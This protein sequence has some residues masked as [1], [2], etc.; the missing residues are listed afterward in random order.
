MKIKA[1]PRIKVKITTPK[2][3]RSENSSPRPPHVIINNCGFINE[4]ADRNVSK[5]ASGT[6]FLYKSITIGIVPYVHKGEI[7]PRKDA[8]TID[9]FGDLLT[10][11]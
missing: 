2:I 11:F 5:G 10:A 4:D 9:T 3:L 7:I 6:L 1:N 8:I